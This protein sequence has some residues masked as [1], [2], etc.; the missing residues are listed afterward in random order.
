MLASFRDLSRVRPVG[1]IGLH[2]GVLRTDLHGGLETPHRAHCHRRSDR[3]DVKYAERR[4][5][6][7]PAEAGELRGR[8]RLDKVPHADVTPESVPFA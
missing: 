3:C 7:Y 5:S 6:R 4:L 1:Q 2:E 8:E